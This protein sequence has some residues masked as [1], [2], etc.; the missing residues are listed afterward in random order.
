[1]TPKLVPFARHL[2]RTRCV[3]C[4]GLLLVLSGCGSGR[5]NSSAPSSVPPAANDWSSTYRGSGG[6]TVHV[7]NG[8]AQPIFVKVRRRDDSSTAAQVD[9]ASNATETVQV[10]SGGYVILLKTVVDGRARFFKGRDLDIPSN[11]RGEAT[12]T[13]GV[14]PSVMG[15]G[16]QE[17]S[18][19]EFRQ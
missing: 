1:M 15:E 13:V 18:A 3:A 17:V 14:S 16:L 7:Q 4:A 19:A 8:S 11:A 2:R 5:A 12:L 9:V 10:D 6:L